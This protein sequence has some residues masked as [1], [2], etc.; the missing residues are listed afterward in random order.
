MRIDLTQASFRV[1]KRAS[2][3]QLPLAPS[4]IS[5]AKLLI[6]LFLEEE[7]RA[8]DWL[9]EAGLSLEAFRT[10][11]GLERRSAILQSP[12]SAPPFPMGNYG[13]PPGLYQGKADVGPP[14]VEASPADDSPQAVQTSDPEPKETPE[15]LSRHADDASKAPPQEPDDWIAS[16][17]TP[18]VYSIYPNRR[19]LSSEPGRQN[20][21]RF[22]LEDDPIPI[23]R[24]S[25]ELESAL[26]I[27]AGQVGQRG[28]RRQRI[29]AS[30][31][32]VASITTRHFDAYLS[33]THPL[34][35]E[36]LL[37]AAA[38]DEDDLGRWLREHGF[39]PT[40]LFDRI[41]RANGRHEKPEISEAVET[42]GLPLPDDEALEG[43][44]DEANEVAAQ[45]S[46]DQL[47]RLLDAVANRAREAVR[48]LEDYVRF[49]LNDVGLTRRLKDIRHELQEMLTPFSLP[50]RLRARNTD[51]DVGTELEGSGEYRRE[52]P[53]DV[54]SANF[55]RLQESLRS[56]E[57]FSKIRHP[58]SARRFER[59]RY[60]S[61]TLHKAVCAETVFELRPTAGP[62]ETP[63][64]KK[65][66]EARLY[67]LI[68][69][70]KNAEHFARQLDALIDGGVDVIQLRDKTADDRTLLARSRILR[71]KVGRIER[72]VLFIMNDRPDLAVLAEADG[73]HVGQEELAIED[74]RKIVGPEMLVGVSTHSIEQA[75]QA[76]SEGADYIGAGPVFESTTKS[77][78]EVAGLDFLRLVAGEISIP[79]FAIGGITT[80]NLDAVLETGIR[81]VAVQSALL[82]AD[83]PRAVAEAFV[84]RLDFQA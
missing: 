44:T 46:G 27:L 34:A 68:D 84:R 7:C 50:D 77:F 14:R 67:A 43:E 53:H 38:M 69:G 17:T 31:G 25:S 2:E 12:I 76:E 29:P 11:F 40:S 51:D 47:Y 20:R 74:V 39:D 72:P 82:A 73:V 24:L 42:K 19:S 52:T 26:E 70:G 10:D 16:E 4:E 18:R 8:A 61:Y 57:E 59:L 33:A 3:Q 60:R 23:T 62:P 54:L 35:T 78:S 58:A 37:L 13:V 30:G 1:L 41:E 55:S 48:V 80:D 9:S 81:R 45:E 64:R 22:Y 36:H 6:A 15:E 71:E 65:M 28:D 56:L 21:V 5:A 32:G 83:D 49:V 63:A 66:A 75:R 79:T